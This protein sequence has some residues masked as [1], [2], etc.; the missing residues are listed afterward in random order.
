MLLKLWENA[1]FKIIFEQMSTVW[2]YVL[3]S[4]TV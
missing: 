1:V 4:D 2:K 3:I